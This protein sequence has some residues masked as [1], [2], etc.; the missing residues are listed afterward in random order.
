LA[1]NTRLQSQVKYH[2]D[3]E[4]SKGKFTQVSDDPE[5]MRVMSTH[6]IISNASYHG[7]LEKKKE[8]EQRRVYLPNENPTGNSN[9][10]NSPSNGSSH[11]APKAGQQYHSSQP[12]NNPN[13]H[14][15]FV[16]PQQQNQVVYNMHNQQQL[17]HIMSQ[18]N[19]AQQH[20]SQQQF[21]SS[22]KILSQG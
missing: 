6:K 9:G 13:R 11:S 22:I 20:Q 5:T 14:Q 8:M 18:A 1:E 12:Q 19:R 7:D 10:N 21:A 16:Q 4:K 15:V 17:P 2:E 3:F